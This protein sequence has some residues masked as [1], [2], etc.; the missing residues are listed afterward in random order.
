MVKSYVYYCIT[1]SLIEDCR[2]GE[3]FSSVALILAVGDPHQF[4]ADPDPNFP[5][6]Q[7]WN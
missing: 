2:N 6:M 1:Y 7:S 4:H 3:G 5:L